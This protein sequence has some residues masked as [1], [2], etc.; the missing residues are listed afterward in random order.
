MALALLLVGCNSGGV[1]PSPNAP[2]TTMNL[3]KLD[4][5]PP[6]NCPAGPNPSP[7]SQSVGPGLGRSPVWAL[8]FDPGPK[9]AVLSR[10]GLLNRVQH[11][12]EL[13]MAWA[14]DRS[15]KS[16]VHVNGTDL[17]TGEDLWFQ[18]GVSPPT[19]A[20]FLDPTKPAAQSAADAQMFPSY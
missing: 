10:P 1:R 18:I 15:F 3:G 8:G 5:A 20:G 9:G 2:I 6:T 13:K 17:L 14:V 4:K 12:F 16:P 19:T 7:I 11:G